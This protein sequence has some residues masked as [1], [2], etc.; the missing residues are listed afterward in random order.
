MALIFAGIWGASLVIS[1]QGYSY[2]VNFVN[3]ATNF[4]WVFPLARKSDLYNVFQKIYSWA[5]R[6]SGKRIRTLQ[7]DTA[8]EFKKLG[9]WLEELRIEHRL[10]TPYLHQQ[11]GH[12]EQK[13]KHLVDTTIAMINHAQ[14][15]QYV[16]LWCS[17]GLLLV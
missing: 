8:L 11:M 13:H 7:S 5:E 14:L 16:G 17:D 2:Y 3:A 9:Q 1:H 4:N 15:S 10:S 6:Q 12:V